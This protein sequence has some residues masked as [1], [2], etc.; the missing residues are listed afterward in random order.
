MLSEGRS[1]IAAVLILSGAA[2]VIGAT[3]VLL[4]PHLIPGFLDLLDKFFREIL[5][6]VEDQTNFEL[7]RGLVRQNLKASLLDLFLGVMVGIVPAVSIGLN[8]FTLG[9]LGGAF[10]LP[11]DV[12]GA[13]GSFS[14][15]LLAILPHGIFELPALILSASFGLRLGIGWLLPSASGHRRGVFKHN[16]AGAVV[17]VPVV[18]VLVVIAGFVEAYVTGS[19]VR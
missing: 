13:S 1:W 7:A 4:F 12:S 17:I 3:T 18:A 16:L 19:L 10:F 11:A 8:F 15:F 5:G 9:F 2:I 14:L 6:D